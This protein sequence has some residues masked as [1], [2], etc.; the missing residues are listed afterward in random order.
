MQ[1]SISE[2]FVTILLKKNE[3]SNPTD[4]RNPQNLRQF[5]MQDAKRTLFLRST[6]F[7][8][9]LFRTVTFYFALLKINF[10]VE[11]N[12]CRTCHI[13]QITLTVPS[14]AQFPAQ[15]LYSSLVL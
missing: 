3:K 9:D 12:G 15:Q 1:K 11:Y 8:F 5:F 4:K 10:P 6:Q 7:R 14:D 13:H 2:N